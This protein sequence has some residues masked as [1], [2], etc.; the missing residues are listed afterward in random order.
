MR[1]LVN[2]AAGDEKFMTLDSWLAKVEK[3]RLQSQVTVIVKSK[4][5]TVMDFNLLLAALCE[6]PYA[7]DVHG[8]RGSVFR[9]EMTLLATIVRDVT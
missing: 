5:D 6:S 9:R 7:T 3:T 8:V 2:K 1:L 4:A